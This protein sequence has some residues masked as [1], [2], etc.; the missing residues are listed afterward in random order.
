[1]AYVILIIVIAV[2]AAVAGGWLLLVR[3]RRRAI[4]H[5]APPT[6][7]PPRTGTS[8]SGTAVADRAEAPPAPPLDQQ[9]P[10]RPVL[11]RP[12]PSAGRLAALRGRLAR[13]QSGLGTVLLGLLSRSSLD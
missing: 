7:E 1:M 8:P 2:L 9:L 10:P 11:D 12:P 3:P 5:P 6:A 4:S 13:S